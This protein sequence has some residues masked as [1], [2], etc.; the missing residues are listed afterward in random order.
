[1]RSV[2]KELSGLL[3][4]HPTKEILPNFNIDFFCRWNYFMHFL[5]VKLKK[6]LDPF[7]GCDQEHRISIKAKW[8]NRCIYLNV[9]GIFVSLL[10]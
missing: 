4:R 2:I 5:A 6:P 8:C 3:A 7:V 9:V 10:L 1:M